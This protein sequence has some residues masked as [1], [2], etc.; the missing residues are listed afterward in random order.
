MTAMGRRRSYLSA[1][2]IAFA[3]GEQLTI[4]VQ[5]ERKTQVL[6]LFENSTMAAIDYSAASGFLWLKDVLLLDDVRF[7]TFGG[8]SSLWINTTVR[9]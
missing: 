8:E 2:H 3:Q 5:F 6:V 7:H 9:N 4:S 1:A